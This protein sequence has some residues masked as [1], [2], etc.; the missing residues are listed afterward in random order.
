MGW[1]GTPELTRRPVRLGAER[2]FAVGDAGGYVEPFTGEGVLWAL[3]GARALA[4]LVARVAERWDPGL[5][6]DG[7]RS[8]QR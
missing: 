1:K 8:I 7:A 4:P 5:L 6:D 3:S 2:L